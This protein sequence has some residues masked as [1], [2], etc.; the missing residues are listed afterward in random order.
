V[1]FALAFFLLAAGSFAG[2]NLEEALRK[3]DRR[4]ARTFLQLGLK[5]DGAGQRATARRIYERVLELHLDEATARRKLGYAKRHG[6]WRREGATGA[7]VGLRKDSDPRQAEL[8]RLRR[9]DLERERAG[10]ILALVRKRDDPAGARPCLL[11]VL[12]YAPRADGVHQALGHQ[13]IDNRWVRP[14]LMGLARAEAGRVAAWRACAAPARV[15]RTGH[16]RIDGVMAVQTSATVGK[17]EVVSAFGEENTGFLA[18]RTEPV[19]R[20]MRLTLAKEPKLFDPTPVYFLDQARYSALVRARHK[21]HEQQRLRLR[22]AEYWGGDCH[23]FWVDDKPHALDLYAHSIAFHNIR[24]RTLPAEP[25]KAGLGEYAWL[26]EGYG[27]LASLELF[28]SALNFFVSSTESSAKVATTTPLPE[29][30]DRRTATAFVREQL[31][32]KALPPLRE[33][34]ASSLNNLDKVRALQAWSFV[35]FLA[36]YDPEGFKRLPAILKEQKTDGRLARSQQALRRAF[37]ADWKELARLWR[38]YVLE[39]S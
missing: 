17:R 12:R 27:L 31:L 32:E 19:F 38:T 30:L 18:A 28:D 7:R 29:R 14:E 34:L 16:H 37:G 9:A 2:D 15:E 22:I 13:R 3:S 21:D 36:L 20:F 35:R 6:I 24:F 8:F 10:A 25:Q 39:L 23:A 33:L 26:A 11:A 4:F 5:A 1:R